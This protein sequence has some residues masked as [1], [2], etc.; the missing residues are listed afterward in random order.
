MVAVQDRSTDSLQQCREPL[1]A[2]EIAEL[3]DVLTLVDDEVEGVEGEVGLAAL[4]ARLEQLE[5]GFAIGP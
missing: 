5:I 3:A 4:E 2:L 1:L